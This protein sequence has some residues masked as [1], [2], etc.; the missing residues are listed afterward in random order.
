MRDT[1]NGYI[2]AGYL[3]DYKDKIDERGF[4]NIDHVVNGESEFRTLIDRV[5]NSFL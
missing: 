5:I 2:Y 1:G 4:A 3:E